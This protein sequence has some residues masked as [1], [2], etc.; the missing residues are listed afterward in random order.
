ME[1]TTSSLF[2]AEMR[3]QVASAEAAVLAAR[4]TDDPML[5][6]SAR[7]H[8]DGLLSLARRNG[9]EI[10]SAIPAERDIDLETEIDITEQ[11]AA[12]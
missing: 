6:E 1:S 11:P 10:T 2:E 7:G 9:L 12:S 5:M 4:T 3:D 8:L